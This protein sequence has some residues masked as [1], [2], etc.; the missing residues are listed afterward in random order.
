MPTYAFR[1]KTTGEVTEKFMHMSDQDSFLSE[2]PELEIVLGANPM[3]DPIR[4]GVIQPSQTFKD[5][6]KRAHD[7]TGGNHHYH[8][9]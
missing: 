1:N 9:A 8:G 3:I 5:L 7:K 4:L 2:H 6:L